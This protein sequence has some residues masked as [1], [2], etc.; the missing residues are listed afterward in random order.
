MPVAAICSRD[1]TTV[2]PETSIDMAFSLMRDRAVRRLPVLENGTL[3]GVISLGVLAIERDP[4]SA[5]AD[6]SNAPPNH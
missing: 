2:T 1:V 5:L 6:I 3:F 4:H